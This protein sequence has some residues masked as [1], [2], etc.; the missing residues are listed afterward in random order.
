[1]SELAPSGS[2]AVSN[3]K[4][5]KPRCNAAKWWSFTLFNYNEDTIGS[6]ISIFSQKCEK[7]IFQEE[8]CPSSGNLHLQ[9]SI[10]LHSKGR[11]LE[12]FA[13]I[14]QAPFHW[15]PSRSQRADWYCEK[16][17]TATGRKWKGGKWPKEI[18]VP[19]IYGWQTEAEE[20][21]LTE[22]KDAT[23]RSVYWW[24]EETGK[25]G[26]SS[27]CKYMAIKHN[28]CV[29]QGGKLADIMNIIFN[30]D[31]D[32]T[33]CV[34]IDIPRAHKNKVSYS[35][36]EC[37]LNG[38]ITNT[39]FETGRKIFNPPQVLVLSNFAPDV[40]D[41]TVSMDRWNIRYLRATPENP[42]G[43]QCADDCKVDH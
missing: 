24:W 36:I 13:K 27:F 3:T 37:I 22:C 25:F 30:T 33:P 15:E 40:S 34:I 43:I 39:K 14:K 12:I 26:K 38:M 18:I 2:N 7:W 23:N 28:A 8:V 19:E 20:L 6:M 21:C 4:T 1:M 31:M 32:S 11:P 10:T 17:D 16:K 29:I 35:S 5:V 42:D 41:E 9:G